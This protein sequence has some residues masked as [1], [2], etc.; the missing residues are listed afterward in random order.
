MCSSI[1]L[2]N[3]LDPEAMTERE[4]ERLPSML[5]ILFHVTLRFSRHLPNKTT[6][7]AL[8]L[9]AGLANRDHEHDVALLLQPH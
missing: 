3:Y 2:E 1:R 9:L 6:F 4:R 8:C 5:F 7:S